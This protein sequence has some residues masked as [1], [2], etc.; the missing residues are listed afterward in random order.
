M[1]DGPTAPLDAGDDP[2]ALLDGLAAAAGRA[3]PPAVVDQVL[4]VDRSRSLG[5]R[6]A[7]RPGAV[8]A[9]RLT[10]ASETLS[11]Q[12]DGRRL[13]TEAAQVSGGVTIARRHPPLGTWLGLFA[14]EVAALAA[15]AAGDTAAVAASLGRLGIR[16]VDAFRVTEADVHGGLAALSAAAATLLPADA[17]TT[18]RRI[19]DLLTDA[20]TRVAGDL[21]S[22][23]EVVVTRT[24]TVYLPDTLRAYAA[25]PGDW[26]ATHRLSDGSTPLEALQRQLGVLETAARAMRD[27]AVERNAS[28]V[29]V[30]G[31]FL[32]DRFRAA[33]PGLELR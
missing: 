25:L 33:D 6:L 17:A 12:L 8:R 23:A 1:T 16:S 7:G 9:V 2:Q 28:E 30:N 29:V 31:R 26:A 27:A 13:V 5:D 24:A 21:A 32:A 19:V 10:G 4:E 15:D 18:V 3:L 20:L 22:D 11:L 14:G